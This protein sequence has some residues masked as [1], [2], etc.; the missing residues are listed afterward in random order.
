[1]GRNISEH[2]ST[3]ELPRDAL[4]GLQQQSRRL[5]KKT[6][7]A[8]GLR[9]RFENTTIPVAILS[10]EQ[11][12]G[13]NHDVRSPGIGQDTVERDVARIVTAVAYEDQRLSGSAATCR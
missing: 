3:A 4:A 6:L 10:I 7:T 9:E 5:R 12:D 2:V 1:M 8:G 13:E 11:P